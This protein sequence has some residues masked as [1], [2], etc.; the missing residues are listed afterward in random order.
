MP[1]SV[2]CPGCREPLDVEDQYRSWKVRCP[3]CR[4]EF[5][6][7]DVAPDPAARADDGSPLP[8]PRRRRRGNGDLS[9]EDVDFRSAREA[10]A[11]P[12]LWLGIVGWGTAVLCLIGAILCGLGGIAA[13]NNPQ[14][15]NNGPDAADLFVGAIFLGLFG[16]PYFAVVGY[17]G[18][19]MQTFSSRGWGITGAI[20]AIVAVI[21][22]PCGLVYIGIGV[23]ALVVLLTPNVTAAFQSREDD[24]EPAPRQWEED[25]WKSDAL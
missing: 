4:H 8:R 13:R 9:Q 3:Q 25:A 7:D 22:L 10:V 19:R 12:G 2:N 24:R 23:W 11:R 18:R 20:M 17:S 15:K 5:C 14:A 1:L 16:V 6:P 21:C